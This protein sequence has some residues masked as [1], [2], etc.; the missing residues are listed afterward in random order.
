MAFSCTAVLFEVADNLTLL[1][2]LMYSALKKIA[3]YRYWKY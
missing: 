3:T 2:L 1:I